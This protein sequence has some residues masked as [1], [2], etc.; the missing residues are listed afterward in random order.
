MTEWMQIGGLA[1]GVASLCFVMVLLVVRRRTAAKPR[2]TSESD[3][4]E[5]APELVLGP[6]TAGFAGA[7]P[8]GRKRTDLLQDLRAA[9]FYRP[10]ALLEYRAVRNLMCLLTLLGT[11]TLA[12]LADTADVLAVLGI[13]LA[14]TVLA[15]S[16]PRLYVVARARIRGRAIERS[17]P[18]AIDML[19]L[20]LSAGQ[21]LLAALQLV[22]RQL[23]RTDTV[24]SQELIIAHQ[25]AELH[26][27]QHA[28]RQW[29]DRVRLQEVRNLVMLLIQS[30][31]LGADAA[32]TLGELAN[33]FRVNARQ[34]AEA[35]ANRASF[36][37][38]FPSVFCF[39]VAAAL[40]LVGPAYLEYF[41]YQQRSA[42][43][44][45]QSVNNIRRV[46]KTNNPVVELPATPRPAATA[47]NLRRLDPRRS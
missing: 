24:L 21:N 3:L 45:E 39:W 7:L 32:T 26:S 40:V 12:L 42:R 14:L 31:K 25:Q 18:L 8:G 11:L 22:S 37:M 47:P 33:N 38:L 16:A 27:L 36:W 23:R 5:P 43:L 19:V 29:A 46:N 28:L 35:Q 44:M 13:G 17:L 41:Q 6:H 10:T 15:F 34:R 20:C 4:D 9:G 2:I 1:L 30:E